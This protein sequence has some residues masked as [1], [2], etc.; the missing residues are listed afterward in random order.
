MTLI[1]NGRDQATT[2]ENAI[3]EEIETHKSLKP[4]LQVILVGNNP[5]S[6]LYVSNKKKACQRVGIE[7]DIIHLPDS[8]TQKEL[9]CKVMEINN[10]SAIHGI[11]VQMPLPAHISAREVIEN[12]APRK[13]VD[14][15]HSQNQIA[16]IQG[17]PGFIP[18]TPRGVLHLIKSADDTLEGK[19]AVVI[20][21]SGLVGLPT[22]QLL[23]R[24]NMTVIHVHGKSRNWE[25]YLKEADVVVAASGQPHLLRGELMG[26]QTIVIDVGINRDARGNL[27]GD[28]DFESCLGKVRAITPVPGG[29]GPMT[30]AYLLRNTVDAAL[31]G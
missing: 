5:P 2:L 27:V 11:L 31:G 1:I 10:N 16:L 18:C 29:V 24:E 12:I 19:T 22:A 25:K 15:L 30:V 21:R 8:T 23:L 4:T 14:G 6:V 3:K 7:V 9:I 26:P 17:R 20:G 28:V 13:D